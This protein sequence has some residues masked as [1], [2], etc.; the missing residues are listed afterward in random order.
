[1]SKKI[2]SQNSIIFILILAFLS[3]KLNAQQSLKLWYD[4][5][6]NS[7][8]K[9][10]GKAWASDGEWLK[11][12]PVGNG[13][14]GAMVFGDV[15][16]E[17]IQINEKTIWSGS[18]DENDNPE[19]PKSL[20]RVRE[21]LFQGKFKEADKLNSATQTCVG[22]GSGNGEGANKPYGSYQTLGDIYFDFGTN[23]P[24]TNYRKELDLNRAVVSVSYTQNGV[25]FKRE[26]FA[27]YPDNSI[28][29]KIS[30]D[31][32]GSVN[33]TC[34][35]NRIERFKTTTEKDHLLMTG[36][37]SDGKGGE[38]LTYA[39][40]LKALNKGGKVTYTDGKIIVKNAD[41]IV[42]LLNAST[43]YKQDSKNY[44]SGKNPLES[45]LIQQKKVAVIP[46]NQ[47]LKRH[48]TDYASLFNRVRFTLAG[49]A[50]E[51][52]LPTD[53]LL[54]NPDNLH[55][56]ELYFQFGRYLLISSSRKG[57]LPANLQGI[58]SNKVQTPWN[59]DYHTNINLQM[60]YWLADATNLSD[61]YTPF[62]D[63]VEST[64]PHGE[65]TAKVQYNA[66]GWCTQVISN[67]WGY[68]SPGEET[69]WGM[70]AVGGGW[71]S[72]QLYDHYRFSKDLNYLKRIYPI[73]LKSSEFFLD[74]LVKDPISG[75]LVSGPSTSPENRFV[76]PDGSKVSISMG[77][78]H[79]QEIIGE[80]FAA[81]L[82]SAKALNEKNAT[83]KKINEAYQNL[84]KPRIGKDGRLM[85]W[86]EEYE[87]VE[88]NHRHVSHLF[89][90]HPGNQIDPIKTPEL[91]S[92]A[93]KTLDKRTDTGTGW[94][95]A[96]KINFFARLH[97]GERAYSLLKKLL[98][99]FGANGERWRHLSKPLLWTPAFS[100]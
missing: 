52:N 88:P 76:A 62:V 64:V 17:R 5:P 29:I 92:A 59:C 55:L 8:S 22:A 79:D 1:M 41:E 83:L 87:E 25:N 73:M 66:N 94:S 53:V 43:N 18:P 20:N 50:K 42:M 14:L 36:R 100:D 63:F 70:Y 81:T 7:Q 58:W 33:F 21:L 6:A 74:W 77:P 47:L 9:D 89:M 85:E 78:S 46:Y 30:A 24:F 80:L 95:L 97:N 15:N 23:A 96:W 54:Q 27:S 86:R 90:L 12:L 38:G 56:H 98:Y 2:T 39:A 19:A 31:K 44:L 84:E 49:S 93:L 45:T 71:L 4:K 10:D 48:V 75:K 11:A 16:K 57:T 72:H 28:V 3:L 67:V 40:R 69:S 51:S 26:I 13:N 34:E 65:K 61:C 82:E 37:L 32:K 91:A 35:L 68:T 60:N 99:I